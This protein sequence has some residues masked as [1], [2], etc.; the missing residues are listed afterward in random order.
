MSWDYEERQHLC[1]E[2]HAK[3]PLPE[4]AF[5]WHHLVWAGDEDSD[6]VRSQA[7]KYHPLIAREFYA[8]MASPCTFELTIDISEPRLDLLEQNLLID[9]ETISSELKRAR[10]QDP[11]RYESATDDWATQAPR[12]LNTYLKNMLDNQPRRSISKRNKRFA[13]IFGPR[14]FDLFRRLEFQEDVMEREDGVDEGTFT[15]RALRT[16]T[17]EQDEET[18]GQTD[19]KRDNEETEIGSYRA[20]IEDVRTEVQSL[21]HRMGDSEEQPSFIHRVLQK[22]MGCS[23]FELKDRVFVDLE[24]YKL[25]GILPEESAEVVVNAY[26]RQWV[27]MFGRKRELIESLKQVAND[28]SNDR[29]SEYAQT[30]S[31]LFESQLEV[32]GNANGE[33][34]GTPLTRIG[35]PALPVGLSNIGNTCYLNSLL[36]YLYTVNGV[37]EIVNNFEKYKLELDDEKISHRKIGGNKMTMSRGEVLV[38]Q[39]CESPKSPRILSCG[40]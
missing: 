4:D 21:I 20:F 32:Q 30:Q 6:T 39:A 23:P 11:V 7:T 3:W 13:V 29:L 15:P 17:P 38:S 14:C 22:N 28:L 37:R 5:P 12:N 36:Q 40:C 27:P 10:E 19:A 9:H 33:K 1:S 25:L 24:R 18:E 8:C 16:S 35:D 2:D 31:S 26:Y 34:E